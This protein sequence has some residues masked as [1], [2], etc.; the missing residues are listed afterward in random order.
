MKIFAIYIL[1][2]AAAC[3]AIHAWAKDPQDFE[4]YN[5]D[6]TDDDDLDD[7]LNN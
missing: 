4:K 5:K 6:Y 2:Y 7:E 1:I 3:F